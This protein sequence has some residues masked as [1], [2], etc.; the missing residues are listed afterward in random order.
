MCKRMLILSAQI[1]VI[2]LLNIRQTELK[3]P[4]SNAALIASPEI[5]VSPSAERVR[6]N[7]REI[8]K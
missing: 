6:E 7:V 4:F 2:T 1:I 5:S 3:V 8:H